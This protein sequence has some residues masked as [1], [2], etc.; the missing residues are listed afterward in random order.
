MCDP[1]TNDIGAEPLGISAMKKAE[2]LE[3][4]LELLGKRKREL[5]ANLEDVDKEI[6]GCEEDMLAARIMRRIE[7]HS[8]SV[9]V[10]D[11]SIGRL[12]VVDDSKMFWARENLSCGWEMEQSG[13]QFVGSMCERQFLYSGIWYRDQLC[14]TDCDPDL[15]NEDDGNSAL[16]FDVWDSVE[17]TNDV[18]FLQRGKVEQQDDEGNKP[19]TVRLFRKFDVQLIT[20]HATWQRILGS[21]TNKKRFRDLCRE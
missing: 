19:K 2:Q 9:Q 6:A 17:E 1:G 13:D 16:G 14:L 15:D 18:Q 7:T 20:S 10:F 21:K 12:L 8:D 4:K 11:S 5:E 3:A